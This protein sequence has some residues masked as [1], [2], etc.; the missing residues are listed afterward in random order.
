MNSNSFFSIIVLFIFCAALTN[1]VQ[2]QDDVYYTPEYNY[3]NDYS[4]G[5]NG[6][7][8]YITNNYYDDDEYVYYDDD[9]YEYR[10]SSRI[11]RFH[12]PFNGFNYY[13]P[14]YTDRYWYDWNN[15]YMWGQSIYMADPFFSPFYYWPSSGFY[16]SFGWGNSWYRPTW[17]SFRNRHHHHHYY[18]PS[19]YYSYSSPWYGNHHHHYYNTGYYGYNNYGYC[20]TSA[21]YYNNSSG[22]IYNEGRSSNVSYGPRGDRGI[23][24]GSNSTVIGRQ[25]VGTS[26]SGSYSSG[27][28]GKTRRGNEVIK[29]TVTP[30][31]GST[32]STNS[33]EFEQNKTPSRTYDNRGTNT[34]TNGM[35]SPPPS[36]QSSQGVTRPVE[37]RW[38]TDKKYESN[39]RTTRPNSNKYE[40]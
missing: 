39:T 14:C 2:A 37:K 40:I 19:Y 20:P 34:N 24:S 8:T 27:S 16:I 26:G 15:P 33:Y 9:D 7:D 11:R 21:V 38:T 35:I 31:K 10:Y 25:V 29:R 4:E 36:S 13:S 6:G 12:R 23:S 28:N 30:S 18:Y 32:I 5:N 1:N 17:R 3:S 22:N